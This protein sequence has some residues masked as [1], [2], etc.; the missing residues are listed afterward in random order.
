MVTIREYMDP[1]DK[2]PYA[3]WFNRL[4]PDPAARIATVLTRMEAGNLSNVKG[5]GHGVFECRVDFG[6]GYRI[7]FGRDGDTLVIL[8]GGGTKRHQKRDVER[9][10]GFWQ[11]YR[12]RKRKEVR[13]RD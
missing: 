9:A 11:E 13:M 1:S 6:P 12:Q 8:L 4:D 3:K 10:Q 5:V 2:S 7:Y